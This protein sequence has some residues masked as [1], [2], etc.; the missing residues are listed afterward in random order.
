MKSSS[1]NQAVQIIGKLKAAIFEYTLFPG[2]IKRN[3]TYISPY[4]E[5]LFETRSDVLLSGTHSIE[6]YVYEEDRASFLTDF[7][8]WLT[9]AEEFVWEGRIVTPI[10]NLKWI[11]ATGTPTKMD[12]GSIVWVGIFTDNTAKKKI[13]QSNY[14]VKV[15]G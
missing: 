3:F 1:S 5:A 14:E 9:N 13:E 6:S 7:S 11:S 2:G 8:K 10:G 4:C 15:A 12:D